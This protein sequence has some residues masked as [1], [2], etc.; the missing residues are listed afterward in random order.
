MRVTA[1]ARAET[2]G[3]TAT[4]IK[5]GNIMPYS[6]PAS[7]YGTIGHGLAAYWK[8]VNDQGGINGRKINFISVD[9]GYIPTKTV[10][11]ARR[12]VEQDGVAFLVNTLGTA[13]NTAIQR[14]LNQKRVP[15]LFVST[16]ADKWGNYKDFPWT[17]GWQ[18]SYRTEAQIYAKYILDTIKDPKIAILYQ[19]DDFGKDYVTGLKDLLGP[20]YD[21]MVARAMSYEVTDPTIDS[22]IVTLQ[23]SGANVLLTA[24]TPKAAAQTIRK[25]FD[26]GWKPT[27]L[28]T[29]VSISAGAVITPA[30]HERAVGIITAGYR[31]DWTDA[32]WSN[33]P[34]MLEWVTFMKNYLP[35]ADLSDSNYSQAHGFGITAAQV[36]R[37]CGA[38][39]SRENIMA[40]AANLKDF[41]VPTLL[42]GIKIN[43]SATNYHPIRQMQLMRWTGTSWDLFGDILEG[44]AV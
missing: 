34:G 42:P 13:Q 20:R 33:D 23:G 15:Q 40:Q 12:L 39:L 36:L 6:G 4:E 24:A 17:I 10:E 27:H 35:N 32:R 22:Q 43:T 2:A 1:S 44:I 3:V 38:D 9:D 25:V 7:S 16:G 31:K 26:L 14:Y 29:N 30:G 37:Q 8:M 28:L 18:P 11:V 21:Q 5:I 41:T 19:N